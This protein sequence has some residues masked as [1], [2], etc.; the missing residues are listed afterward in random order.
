MPGTDNEILNILMILL[1]EESTADFRPRSVK[2]LVCKNK[3]LS[4][5][6]IP[7]GFLW[8][9][10]INCHIS[11]QFSLTL[12]QFKKYNDS[13]QS[14]QPCFHGLNA[15]NW[16][17]INQ[18]LSVQTDLYLRDSN[19]LKEKNR[20]FHKSRNGQKA[21]VSLPQFNFFL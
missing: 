9:Y 8:V 15:P 17:P 2:N 7:L 1:S 18:F 5:L 16:C 13:G 4:I 11:K 3:S 19:H 21:P 10:V 6:S 12:V 20:A 14:Y